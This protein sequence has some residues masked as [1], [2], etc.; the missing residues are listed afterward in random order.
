MILGHSRKN[1]ISP[2]WRKLESDPPPLPY[3]PLC[4]NTLIVIRNKFLSSPLP[5]GRSMLR[6]VAG[7][8][9]SSGT[10]LSNDYFQVME[11]AR[12]D[13]EKCLS[14]YEQSGRIPTTIME[15][16]YGVINP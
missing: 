4:P 5:D 1:I 2:P 11:Q 14:L 7:L 13:V 15:A 6:R 16:R 12:S 8:W 9:I 10:T 3:Y